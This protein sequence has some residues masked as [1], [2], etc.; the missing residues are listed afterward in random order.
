MSVNFENST[1]ILRSLSDKDKIDDSLSSLTLIER[2][3]EHLLNSSE[4]ET[5][6]TTRLLNSY[7]EIYSI[8]NIP[9][10]SLAHALLEIPENNTYGAWAIYLLTGRAIFAPLKNILKIFSELLPATIQKSTA[11]LNEQARKK[12]ESSASI[13]NPL[14]RMISKIF[15]TIGVATSSIVYAI[16]KGISLL[17]SRITSP[18]RTFRAAK[19]I[20]PV[21]GVLSAIVTVV[22]TSI[23]GF[24]AAPALLAVL[25]MTG[26]SVLSSISGSITT[27]LHAAA[28]PIANLSGLSI[29]TNNLAATGAAI[30]SAGFALV[31][32]PAKYIIAKIFG[33]KEPKNDLIQQLTYESYE[34]VNVETLEDSEQ[35]EKNN[36]LTHP[37]SP[38]LSHSSIL[39]KI[40]PRNN[41]TSIDDA[42]PKPSLQQLTVISRVN[43]S[44][45]SVRYQP[46]LPT[47]KEAQNEPKEPAR[48]HPLLPTIKE[49]QQVIAD[50]KEDDSQSIKINY[51]SDHLPLLAETP[52]DN[53][54]KLKTI[55]WNV[56]KPNSYSG[57]V[58]FE[59]DEVIDYR[60]KLTIQTIEKM[61]S[62]HKPDAILLQEAYLSAENIV[63]TIS[64]YKYSLKTDIAGRMT[65]Y[66]SATLELAPNANISKHEDFN[67]QQYEKVTQTLPFILLANNTSVIINNV[68]LP[69]A[70][71]P[72]SAEKYIK[73]LLSIDVSQVIVAGD[74][75]NRCIP[76]NAQAGQL[77]ANNVVHPGFRLETEMQGCDFTDGFFYANNEKVCHQPEKV[78]VLNPFN[79]EVITNPKITIENYPSTQISELNSQKFVLG[80]STEYAIENFIGKDL[81]Q[82]LSQQNIFVGLTSNALSERKIGIY[83]DYTKTNE[84]VTFLK[85]KL[86]NKDKKYSVSTVRDSHGAISGN[87]IFIKFS[88][89]RTLKVE[90]ENYASLITKAFEKIYSAIGKARK[91]H[92]AFLDQLNQKTYFEKLVIIET[93]N[94]TDNEMINK[95]YELAIK[96]YKNCDTTNIELF[97]EIYLFVEEKTTFS[98]LKSN[99]KTFFNNNITNKSDIEIAKQIENAGKNSKTS[100]I[101]EALSP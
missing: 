4:F 82:M 5:K 94:Q 31:T 46:L 45:E 30:V 9:P 61:I 50:F 51:L 96:N 3:R 74:F 97:K 8:N 28:A 62:L 15:F 21:L 40:Q 13:P 41:N 73:T 19:N 54:Q 57:L 85:E 20:H 76:I 87:N 29:L 42:S 48:Y 63:K 78:F 56:L 60:E 65:I 99:I 18:M 98:F 37:S 80:C 7:N 49:A 88:S 35:E 26:S 89:I 23:F 71:Y 39:R 55:I 33:K 11:W 64:S 58:A 100:I 79:A 91:L 70:D 69:H 2:A 75:N 6:L 27:M 25:P 84:L 86:L 14:F 59:S 43:E 66:N 44:N 81:T 95:S 12:Y 10:K 52:L 72:Q 67:S 93:A 90:I 38:N 68:H 47:I 36:T 53:S 34:H 77:I 92:T 1:V 83:L 101:K 22:A 32:S 16:T 17:T 24:F